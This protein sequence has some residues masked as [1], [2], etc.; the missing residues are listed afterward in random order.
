M[1]T[2]Y[3][4]LINC[5]VTPTELIFEFSSY[6]PDRPNIAPPA[7]L[8]PDVRIVMNANILEQLASYFNQIVAQRKA[9]AP[10]AANVGFV[11]PA[12]PQK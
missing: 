2:F 1:N 4:N 9:A 7:D 3:S 10:T 6:F 11:P 12:A 5:K 8:K